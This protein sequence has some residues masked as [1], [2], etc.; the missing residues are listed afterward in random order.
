MQPIIRIIHLTFLVIIIILISCHDQNKTGIQGNELMTVK[1]D[2]IKP[3]EIDTAGEGWGADIKLSIIETQLSDSCQ[4]YKAV[5]SY[6]EKTLGLIIVIPNKDKSRGFGQGIVLKSIGVESDQL[7]Q[8]LAKLYKQK[9]GPSLKFIL[10]IS[11]SYLNMNEF[12]KS[13]GGDANDR[14]R[15]YKVF[16]ES[17]D[18]DE[19]ELFLN[20]NPSEDWIQLAEKDE[21]YRPAIIKFLRQ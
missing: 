17:Q 1:N 9:T 7:L 4:T 3:L 19:A 6:Q 18:G 14:V 20:V 12:V 11:L 8:Q 15:E 5:S 21:E 10:S 16:F 2:K 13:L